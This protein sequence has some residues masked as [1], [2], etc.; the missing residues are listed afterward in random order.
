MVISFHIFYKICLH[1]A[2]QLLIEKNVNCRHGQGLGCLKSRTL[3]FV[4]TYSEK[5]SQYYFNTT[6]AF[7]IYPANR[8]R[9]TMFQFGVK[10]GVHLWL[11]NKTTKETEI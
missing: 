10:V 7:S 9:N 3:N 1:L 8:E 5:S 2:G 4:S 11:G 6:F